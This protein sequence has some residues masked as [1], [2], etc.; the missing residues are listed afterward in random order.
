LL[1]LL[2]FCYRYR[3]ACGYLTVA[4]VVRPVTVPFDTVVLPQFCVYRL[5]TTTL[6]ISFVLPLFCRSAVL[7]CST[8]TLGDY[9]R[10]MPVP[11]VILPLPFPLFVTRC[12]YVA[13]CRTLLFVTPA[14]RLLRFCSVPLFVYVYV[15]YRYRLPVI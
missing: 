5:R 4:F 9:L 8:V 11:V 1:R 15:R 14:L 10:Y 2:Q 13:V 7:R 6:Y 12:R 3:S